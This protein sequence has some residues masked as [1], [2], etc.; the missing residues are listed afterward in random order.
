MANLLHLYLSFNDI[1]EIKG[2]SRLKKLKELELDNNRISI[3][4][5]LKG[6]RA[7]EIISLEN[8][9]LSPEYYT[10]VYEDEELNQFTH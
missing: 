7:L 8:N 6:L 3:I 9:P 5:G 10:D 2:L 1:D 4:K